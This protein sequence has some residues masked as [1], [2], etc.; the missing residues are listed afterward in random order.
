MIV[1]KGQADELVEY[2]APSLEEL[3][4]LE[5]EANR[6][7][8]T[9]KQQAK[10]LVK[11]KHFRQKARSRMEKDLQM[12]VQELVVRRKAELY[13]YWV[14]A[15][16]SA[17]GLSRVPPAMWREG[18]EAVLDDGL[19]WVQ[20]QELMGV[21]D[22]ES[23]E[24][25]YV[26]FLD[27][28]RVAFDSTFGIATAN[29]Q[30]EVW[31]RIMETLVRADL[32]L[33]EALAAL[34]A[35]SDGLVSAVEFTRLLESCRVRITPMQARIMLRSVSSNPH[36]M[37]NQHLDGVKEGAAVA[38]VGVWDMLARLT[39][40]LPVASHCT[41]EEAAWAVP[42]LRPLTEAILK[43]AWGRLIPADADPKEWATP[44]II[45]AWFEDMDKDQNGYL[46]DPEF[47]GGLHA[48]KRPLQAAGIPTDDVTFR[49]FLEACDVG[50]N[51]H[52][53]Y[54]ELLNVLTWEETL[55]DDLQEELMETTYAAIYF[56]L[57][58]IRAAFRKY[59]SAYTGWVSPEHFQKALLAVRT[60]LTASGEDGSGGLGQQ[61]IKELTDNLPRQ[62]GFIN[63]D[64]FLKSFRIVDS[65]QIMTIASQKSLQHPSKEALDS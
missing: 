44:K 11:Q 60:A 35:T 1:T 26:D 16:V 21:V 20:L 33:R 22:Q 47:L 4:A 18:C 31:A 45:A 62:D 41:N 63:Y 50:G 14:D 23:G 32:P 5:Q 36:S 6:A 43:D 54:F 38:R 49:R 27:R 12:K 40:S 55:G 59:D 39:S 56:N 10:M 8:V 3:K 34:D 42:K 46:S 13:D 28:Y 65:T 9:L 52:L 29:W 37:S 17:P 53:N 48:L 30:K 25:Q 2:W 58:S 7:V 24:V 61:E 64:G 19:P 51:G 57:S 15:D